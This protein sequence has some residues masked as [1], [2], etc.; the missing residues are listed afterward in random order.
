VTNTVAA[1]VP[2][3][4]KWV[5]QD[6]MTALTNAIASAETV[7]DKTAATQAEVDAA[8]T[9]LANATSAFTTAKKDGTKTETTA[10]NKTA[11]TN[12]I[13]AANTAKDGVVTNT[14]AANVPVGT[15]WVTQAEMTAMANAI[16]SA[17]T[18]KNNASATQTEVDAAT[19]VLA[20]ATSAFTTAKKDGTKTETI[21]ANKTALTNAISTANTAKDGVIASATALATGSKWVLPDDLAAF[22]TAIS[23]AQAVADN[24]T[25]TQNEVDNAVTALN[26][27][28]STFN[29]KVK[30][31]EA[32]A[33]GS[34]SLTFWVNESDGSILASNSSVEITKAQNFTATVTDAYTTVQWYVDGAAVAQGTTITINGTSYGIGK[35]R[36]GV[37]VSKGGVPYSKEIT[38]TVTE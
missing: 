36:L 7:K 29:G 16:A 11:L 30:N 25:A 31:V 9:A 20:N 14:T 10:A 17:E 3:G 34:V 35:H 37:R 26:T 6:E 33:K 12:A 15:K 32:G 18:V 8:T 4:T 13:N 19:T 28:T 1:N 2:V 24:A 27:A 5:T 38:F 23:A 22:N 21:A